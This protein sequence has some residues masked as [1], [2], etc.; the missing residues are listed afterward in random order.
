MR[1][2]VMI[3]YTAL[4]EIRYAGA[5]TQERDAAKRAIRGALDVPGAEVSAGPGNTLQIRAALDADGPLAAAALLDE[6]VARALIATG[7][8]E[9]FDM[10][11][12]VLHAAP[13]DV[14][15]QLFAWSADFSPPAARPTGGRRRAPYWRRRRRGRG[16]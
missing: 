5:Q 7:L 12:R 6:A 15:D 14:A 1:S 3:A 11:R 8:F 10:A 2:D 9:E 13:R 4:I 16:C